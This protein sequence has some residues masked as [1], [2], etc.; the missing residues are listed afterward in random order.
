[1]DGLV[2]G[3]RDFP[4]PLDAER[5][6]ALG[7][8]DVLRAVVQFPAADDQVPRYRCAGL[9]IARKDRRWLV[10]EKMLYS[11]GTKRLPLS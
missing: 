2:G 6:A 9:E 4:G 3:R 10:P 11:A 7:R 1:V 8:R 5:V